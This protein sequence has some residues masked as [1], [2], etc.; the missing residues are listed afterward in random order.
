MAA[1]FLMRLSFR[2]ACMCVESLANI[3]L[4]LK[5]PDG[6]TLKVAHKRLAI[7]NYNVDFLFEKPAFAHIFI[8]NLACRVFCFLPLKEADTR[9]YVPILVSGNCRIFVECL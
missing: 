8:A 3:Y 5:I 4:P 7:I 6:Q 9:G 1:V 2:L